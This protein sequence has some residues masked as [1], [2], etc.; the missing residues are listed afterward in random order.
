M[1]ITVR[2]GSDAVA[3]QTEGAPMVPALIALLAVAATAVPAQQATTLDAAA[4]TQVAAAVHASPD[5]PPPPED[6]DVAP[7]PPSTPEQDRAAEE[8]IE[9]YAPVVRLREQVE[10]CGDGEPYLPVDVDVVLDDDGVALRG[11]WTSNDLVRIAPSADQIGTGLLEYHLDFPGDALDPGCGY[12]TWSRQISEGTAPT[13]YG[14][15]VGDPARPGQLAVQYWFFYVY[16]DFNNLHEGDWE[17]IQLVIDAPDAVAALDVEPAAVGYSQHSSA[18]RATWGEDKLELV[19][20]THPVVYPA[21]GSHANFFTSAL[22]LGASSAAGVGCDDTTGPHT[23]LDLRVDAVPADTD[24]YLSGHPWLGFEGRW[25]ERQE[26]FYNGP[27]GPNMK[28]QWTAPIRWSEDSWRDSSATVPL[29]SALG[30]SATDAFC[31]VVEGGS[32][33]LLQLIRNPE[34]VLLVLAVIVVALVVIATRTTWTPSDPYPV[35][36][37]RSWGRILGAA[38]RMYGRHP[39]LFSGIGLVYVPVMFVAVGLQW[40]LVEA[41]ELTSL[42]DTDGDQNAATVF[43]VVLLGGAISLLAYFCVVAAVAQALHDLDAGRPV[44]VLS[45]YREVGRHLRPLALVA[46]RLVVVCWALLFFVFTAPLALIYAVRNGFAVQ[47]VMMEDRSAG[48]AFRRSR[49]VVRGHW[50]RTTAV[51]ALVVGLGATTGPL[52]GIILLLVSDGSF[53]VINLITALVYVV[54]IPFVALVLGYLYLDLRVRAGSPEPGEA[55]PDVPA[56]AWP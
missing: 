20:G 52:V 49:D 44:T 43:V 55:R 9:R 42:V 33:L 1:V 32:N 39:L 18:E 31:G 4:A 53:T 25:G 13:T 50:W 7:L 27:T 3:I 38:R 17:M 26:A 40:V 41:G 22:Y 16:N 47:A 12:E 21:E 10:P 11:P 46:A 2:R 23:E 30:T 6:D 19:D 51:T 48:D 37:R 56:G 45:A 15:V 36:Q 24:D 34:A 29:G 54:T 14:R 5:L 8:L 28:F 35:A